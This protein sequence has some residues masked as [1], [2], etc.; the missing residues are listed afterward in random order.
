[1]TTKNFQGLNNKYEKRKGQNNKNPTL[2]QPTPTTLSLSIS[3]D[4]S[5]SFPGRRPLSLDPGAWSSGGGER[6]RRLRL[7]PPRRRLRP[8]AP[9]RR[10]RPLRRELHRAPPAPP[11]TPPSRATPATPPAPPGT[12]PRLAKPRRRL[13]PTAP[14]QPLRESCP[15]PPEGTPGKGDPEPGGATLLWLRA[16]KR[17]PV[18]GIRGAPHLEPGPKQPFGRAPPGA[19]RGAGAGAL[20]NRPIGDSH[21]RTGRRRRRG[22]GL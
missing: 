10:L 17:A 1:V 9:R 12:P 19:A 13:R 11:A 15:C 20:P 14:R 7:L 5:L 21:R 22:R 18:S 16:A 6:G 2:S 3:L 4:P 8:A